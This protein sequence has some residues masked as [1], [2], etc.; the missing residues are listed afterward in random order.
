MFDPAA[1][2]ERGTYQQPCQTAEGMTAVLVAG[3]RAVTD[4][5]LT[6]VKAGAVIRR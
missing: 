5:Q 2:R 3:Q 4:G 1:L 6:G